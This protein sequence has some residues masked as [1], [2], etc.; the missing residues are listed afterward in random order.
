[1]YD[2][3]LA[4]SGLRTTQFAILALLH[5]LEV[6]SVNE[7]AGRLDLDRTTTGKNLRPLEQAGLIKTAPSPQDRRSRE[8]TLTAKGRGALKIAAPMWQEAQREFEA[9]NGRD[10]SAELRATLMGI[11]V[12]D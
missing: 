11:K 9:L 1:M 2:A 3:K 10:N 5:D 6:L 12:A 7:L 4:G 8:T